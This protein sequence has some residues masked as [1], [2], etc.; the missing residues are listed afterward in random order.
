MARTRAKAGTSTASKDGSD[1]G[2]T[3]A[4][5]TA[6]SSP[7]I[8]TL[9]A[10]CENPPKLF[11]L[12]RNASPAARIVTL[13]HP[14]SGRP[15][16]FLVCPEAGFF[17]FTT[18]SPPPSS[19]RSWLVQPGSGSRAPTQTVQSPA[20]H[21][22]TPFD[23]LFLLLPALCGT[24]PGTTTTTTTTTT[25]ASTASTTAA[26]REPE[27]A[28]R[29]QK[30]AQ[31]R[32]FLSLD[33]HLDAAAGPSGHLADLAG[34]CAATRRRLEARAAAVCDTV[35]AG[36]ET[37]YR[38]SGA[39]LAREL[40]AKAR[41]TTMMGGG[42]D[43]RLPASL[44]DRFVRREL[45]PPVLGVRIA[46]GGSGGNGGAATPASEGGS[47][48][49]GS[50][51]SS[52][53]SSGSGSG[54]GSEGSAGT[55]ASTPATSVAGPDADGADDDDGAATGAAGR[56][57]DEVVRLQRLRVALDFICSRYV[58]PAVRAVLD[59]S[60][61]ELADPVDFG[62]LDDHLERLA[63]LRQ[64]AA[65]ARS[66]DFSRKRATDEEQDAR[67]E[68]KRKQEAEEKA[69]K[70]NMSRGVRNLMKV[71]TSGMKKMSDFFKKKT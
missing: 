7:S 39:K 71:D 45:E 12:P 13:P 42:G 70:A 30:Q 32:M 68:K 8:Y 38:L 24:A 15:A 2:T 6:R 34:S 21:L 9:P 46:R 48:S 69:R 3:A 31:K 53:A 29:G 40:L 63:K 47:Q 67:A 49:Q 37:M 11:V 27:Q 28:R 52:A 5:G 22:A 4:T 41:R 1:T 66:A 43:G 55:T 33:D 57:S 61:A 35:P 59:E 18:V 14:R 10:E 64:E 16:R 51:V 65:A 19:P 58:P 54:S 25:T 60:L 36:D 56:P 17:E 44:E 20:L 26:G 23:P 50:V 62:P